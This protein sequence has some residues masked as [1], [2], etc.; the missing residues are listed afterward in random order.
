MEQAVRERQSRML[1]SLVQA[2]RLLAVPRTISPWA[3][4]RIGGRQRSVCA[5]LTILYARFIDVADTQA[6]K[7]EA[8]RSEI[9]PVPNDPTMI[10]P[11]VQVAF[12]PFYG[13]RGASAAI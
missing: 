11:F 1:I 6:I 12:P 9:L 5:R 13:A 3:V 8:P 7:S 4:V 10:G 2:S